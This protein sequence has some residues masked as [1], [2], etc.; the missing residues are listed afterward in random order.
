M[1]TKLLRRLSSLAIIAT[2]LTFTV[3]ELHILFGMIPLLLG[4]AIH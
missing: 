2:S 4:V 1:N 3:P